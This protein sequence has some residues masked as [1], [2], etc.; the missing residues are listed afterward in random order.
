MAGAL[1]VLASFAE[2]LADGGVDIPVPPT[3]VVKVGV[4]DLVKLF[5][6]SGPGATTSAGLT[7][8]R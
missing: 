5:E 2:G 8:A 7:G 4:D 1:E 6:R 3:F